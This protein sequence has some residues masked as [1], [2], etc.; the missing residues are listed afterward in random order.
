MNND[1]NGVALKER[2]ILSKSVFRRDIV[3]FDD[4]DWRRS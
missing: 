1:W 3:L 4:E 2:D